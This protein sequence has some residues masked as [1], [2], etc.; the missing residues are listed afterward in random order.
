MKNE[1]RV[2]KRNQPHNVNRF[3]T[4]EVRQHIRGL[5]RGLVQCGYPLL[6]HLG[7]LD[8]IVAALG[9]AERSAECLLADDPFEAWDKVLEKDEWDELCDT[10][11]KQQ[12]ITTA[13]PNVKRMITRPMQQ[14]LVEAIKRLDEYHGC[15]TE[16]VDDLSKRE[17]FETAWGF[18]KDL[19]SDRPLETAEARK[20]RK[21][22]ETEAEAEAEA[23]DDLDGL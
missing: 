17:S 18:A 6:D 11:E 12:T 14:Q 21:E 20:K 5:K 23:E 22:A 2:R 1:M 19:Q 16:L 13:A 9:I 4:P 8:T 3:I 7:Y 15:L 10:T